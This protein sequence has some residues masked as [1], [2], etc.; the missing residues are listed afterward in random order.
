MPRRDYRSEI[1]SLAGGEA[2]KRHWKALAVLYEAK[3]EKGLPR[4]LIHIGDGD[5]DD[6]PLSNSINM[7]AKMPSWNEWENDD[8]RK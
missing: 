2:A 5:I 6:K 4:W 7:L 1:I 8:E 3:I